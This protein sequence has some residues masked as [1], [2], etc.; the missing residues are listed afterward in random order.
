MS[1]SAFRLLVAALAITSL[2]ACRPK[3]RVVTT[4]P[5]ALALPPVCP[6]GVTIF[7]TP[8]VV[9]GPVR[10]VAIIEAEGNAVWTRDAAMKRRMQEKAGQLGAN[11]IIVSDFSEP[12]NTLRLI[13]AALGGTEAAEKR[14]DALAVYV[15]TLEERAR[16]ICGR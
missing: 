2:G 16:S 4:D 10:E 5:G 12:K 13:G 14:G 11:A 7:E 6:D 9:P 1:R 15:P 8:A 3:T